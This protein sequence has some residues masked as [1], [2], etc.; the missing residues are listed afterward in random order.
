VGH[1]IVDTRRWRA[2]ERPRRLARLVLAPT[3]TPS[4]HL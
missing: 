4:T 2:G 1:G 3:A